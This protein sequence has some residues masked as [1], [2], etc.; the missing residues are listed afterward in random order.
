MN[1]KS[2]LTQT[3]DT[4][5]PGET[6]TIDAD[7]FLQNPHA[8]TAHF[9]HQRANENHLKLSPEH[10]EIIDL[11]RGFYLEHTLHLTNRALVKL[12]RERFGPDKGNS[13]YL[14]TLFPGSPARLTALI[15]GLPKPPFCF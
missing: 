5:P 11:V 7:G 3:P 1:Q 12:T 9:A 13:I 2:P 6:P 15:G 4:A 14:Q 10:L 8:W